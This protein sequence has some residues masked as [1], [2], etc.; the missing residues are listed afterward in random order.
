MQKIKRKI[1]NW[2]KWRLA[3]LKFWANGT[4]WN[5]N[6]VKFSNENLHWRE[7]SF[8]LIVFQLKESKKIG[9]LLTSTWSF[10]QTSVYTFVIQFGQM[11]IVCVPTFVILYYFFSLF[12]PFSVSLTRCYLLASKNR[13][14][15]LITDWTI[16]KKMMEWIGH[17]LSNGW[18]AIDWINTNKH[19]HKCTYIYDTIQ[20]N[21]H[22]RA[23]EEK[24]ERK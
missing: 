9:I 11:W 24:K 6:A 4:V 19:E 12:L 7:N 5:L 22:K 15:K 16:R 14:I 10:A 18:K 21:S 2:E 1:R 17:K 13:L 23:H 3:Y 8:I 20:I